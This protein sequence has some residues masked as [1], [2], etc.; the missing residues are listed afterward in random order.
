M[1][2]KIKIKTETINIEDIRKNDLILGYKTDCVYFIKRVHKTWL[3]NHIEGFDVE[4][5]NKTGYTVSGFVSIEEMKD[6]KLT[7]KRIIII[8]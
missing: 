3:H 8:L 5:I 7:R 2:N 4:H 1:V 6:R